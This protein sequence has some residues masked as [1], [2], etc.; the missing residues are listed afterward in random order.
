MKNTRDVEI[1]L[2]SIQE[3]M[4]S[5]SKE[6]NKDLLFNLGTADVTIVDAMFFLYLWKDLPATFGTFARFLQIKAFA[7][8]G[9]NIH[10][11]FDKVAS[12]SIKDYE[13]DSRS[14]YQEW[15]S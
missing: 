7:Q 3:N 13:R 15:G 10:L 8:K 9:N 6:M 5:F 14:G 11:V 4:K 2:R 12:P 1:I